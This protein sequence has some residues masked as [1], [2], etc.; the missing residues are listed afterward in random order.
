VFILREVLGYHATEVAD[1]L[2]ATVESVTSALKRARATLQP[3]LPPEGEHQ[4]PPA[5][6]SP[7]EQALVAKFVHA[8][9]SGDVDALVALLT[10]D[11]CVSMPTNSP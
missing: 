10:A 3:R 7:A 2:D 8:Y 1:M 4:P 5:P 9:Q 6:D 11:V